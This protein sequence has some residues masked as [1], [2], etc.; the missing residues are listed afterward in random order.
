[1][2]V[3]DKIALSTSGAPRAIGP[4]SQGI[5]K[6]GWIYVSGQIPLT[7]NGDLVQSDI[8][9]Q[10]RQC[11]DNVRAVLKAAGADVRDLVKVTVFVTDIAQFSDINQ[12]Y[13][14]F[15]KD[16]VPPA[17]SLIQAAALPRNVPIE[18]EAVASI[19]K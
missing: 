7:P 9:A 6:D 17:R 14:D 10:T 18:I 8:R 16:T 19:K 12:E 11:L 13:A 5:A 4:Y 2:A 1:M 3:H 15:F